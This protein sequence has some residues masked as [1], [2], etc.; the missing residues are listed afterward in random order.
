MLEILDQDAGH[1][2]KY[3]FGPW[4]LV[5]QASGTMIGRGGLRWTDL[6]EG[7]A[8]EAP[9]TIRSDKWGRGYA[10]EA[11]AAALAWARSLRLTEVIALVRPDN[12]AS[13]RV[14]KKAGFHFDR[15]TVHA[16]LP[17]LL[18]R[19]TLAPSDTR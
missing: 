12:P 18:F 1:W 8:V 9:W 17:H 3:G 4:V 10:S 15:E 19:K 11:A 5:E 14:A 13:R 7:R 2:E 6:E 16:G